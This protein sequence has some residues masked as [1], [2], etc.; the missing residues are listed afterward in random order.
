MRDICIALVRWY[1]LL[2]SPVLPPSCRFYPTCSHYAIEAFSRHGAW[3]GLFLTIHRLL[4]CHPFH[5]GGFDP[6]PPGPT[7]Q[8][9][10]AGARSAE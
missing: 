3:R 5:P 6:V 8:A 9:R 10:R 7:A 1:Q 4:R 2:L